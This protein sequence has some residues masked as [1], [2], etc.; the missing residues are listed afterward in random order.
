MNFKRTFFIR[1]CLKIEEDDRVYII[2]NAFTRK[3]LLVNIL[4]KKDATLISEIISIKEAVK[5]YNFDK[6]HLKIFE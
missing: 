3:S 5:K 4:F 1:N 2:S 6:N